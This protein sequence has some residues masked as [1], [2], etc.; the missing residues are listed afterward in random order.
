M[1]PLESCKI[2]SWILLYNYVWKISKN[3]REIHEHPLHPLKVTVWCGITSSRIIGPYFLK[4]LMAIQWLWMETDID[5]C[6]NSIFFVRWKTWKQK[7]SGSQQD[8]AKAHTEKRNY[9][10][11]I[12]MN[13]PQRV[14]SR[15][16]G[17]PWQPRSP[18]LSPL[19]FSLG[20]FKKKSSHWQA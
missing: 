20:I 5:K 11:A 9:R 15:L 1:Q 2:N 13:F 14:I 17:V 3:L 8:G 19:T 4:M 7:R 10:H 6:C 18:D 16:G 12:R